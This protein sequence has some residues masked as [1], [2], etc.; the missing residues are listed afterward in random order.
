MERESTPPFWVI[1]GVVVVVAATLGFLFMSLRSGLRAANSVTAPTFTPL[2]PAT[3]TP[4]PTISTSPLAPSAQSVLEVPTMS[5]PQVPELAPD[6]TLE[7]ASG[8][9]FTLVEQLAWGP[10]ALVFMQSGGG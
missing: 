10:V 2:P 1:F 5:P 6:F 7:Q 3:A 4:I 9:T 8:G